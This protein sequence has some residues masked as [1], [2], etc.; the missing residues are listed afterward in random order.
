MIWRRLK[1]PTPEQEQD[2]QERMSD[3]QVTW[4]DKLAMVLSAYLAIL[5]PCILILVAFGCLVLWIFGAF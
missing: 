1:K 2:F 5:L 4:K 3:A